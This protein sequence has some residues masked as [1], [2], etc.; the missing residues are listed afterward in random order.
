MKTDPPGHAF[1]GKRCVDGKLEERT[2]ES[3]EKADL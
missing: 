1:L 2:V 3:V